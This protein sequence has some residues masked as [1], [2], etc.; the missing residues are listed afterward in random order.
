[1]NTDLKTASSP[2]FYQIL[3]EEARNLQHKN[4]Q[5][6]CKH[7][8]V[9]SG[10]Q[11]KSGKKFKNR[12]NQMT[13]EARLSKAHGTDRNAVLRVR[14]PLDRASAQTHSLETHL[15]APRDSNKPERKLTEGKKL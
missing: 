1:M 15:R 2:A 7:N 3:I 6:Q 12:Q 8:S 10:S 5:E 11:E 14:A 4:P 13:E 9:I